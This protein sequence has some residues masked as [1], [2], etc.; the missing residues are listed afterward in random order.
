MAYYESTFIA[1]Q[2]MSTQ[3][4]QN[5]TDNYTKIIAEN[6]GA[7]VKTEYWGLKTLAYIIKKNR[8]GHYV[9]IVSDAPY[10]AV[11]E[12]ERRMKINEDILRHMTIKVDEVDLS[13]S[14]M[15]SNN[16]ADY[17]IE[18]LGT[19]TVIEEIEG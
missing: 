11:K 9:M 1:R 12:M 19:K 2:D 7:V 8:K 3:D 14:P 5:L 18:G 17:E 13:P 4:V 10:D 6:G 16:S 15:M